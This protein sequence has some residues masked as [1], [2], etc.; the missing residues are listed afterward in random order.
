MSDNLFREYEALFNIIVGLH[1]LEKLKNL[2][3]II[4]KSAIKLT[5]AEAASIIL[6]NPNNDF[7]EFKASMGGAKSNVLSDIKVPENSIAGY[8][9]K[10]GKSLLIEDVSKDPR[11]YKGVQKKTNFITRSLI[12]VPLIINRET[13]GVMQI[14]NSHRTDQFTNRD[15]KIFIAFASQAAIAI[16]NSKLYEEIILEKE[17]T[18]LI[19]DQLPVGLIVIDNNLNIIAINKKL[20]LILGKNKNI[21][22]K[23]IKSLRDKFLKFL[24]NKLNKKDIEFQYVINKEYEQLDINVRIKYLQRKWKG[25]V[26]IIEDVTKLLKIKEMAA[27]QDVARKLAHELKNPLTPIQLAAQYIEYLY[28]KR[29]T[30]FETELKK[31]IAIINSQIEKLKNM[32]TEFSKFARLPLPSFKKSNINYVIDSVINLYKNKYSNIKFVIDVEDDIPD[33]YFDPSQIEQVII[34]II[35]NGIEAIEEVKVK[36]PR[37]LIRVIYKKRMK[38]IGI[39]IENNGP[40]IPLRILDNIFRPYLTTKGQKGTGLGMAISKRIMQ[41]HGGDIMVKNLN[42]TGVLFLISLPVKEKK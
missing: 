1:R 32:L 16:V 9:Y 42:P 18:N 20:Q 23:N 19:I 31:H 4:L 35:K 27:W 5:K 30:N 33:A 8:V 37:I 40:K 12:C 26:V 15:L 13:I 36:D 10:T 6:K 41:Q 28:I 38:R 11:F 3:D 2:L 29:D 21:I 7:L 17:M 14:L 25:Y 22:G 24:V 39:L 34:N